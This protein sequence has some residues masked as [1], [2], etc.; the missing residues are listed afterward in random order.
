[1]ERKL[2]KMK[3]N[4]TKLILMSVSFADAQKSVE[5]IYTAR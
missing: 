2:K 1:M 4:R 3:Y 5:R